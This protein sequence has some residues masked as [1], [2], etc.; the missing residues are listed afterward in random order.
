MVCSPIR[1]QVVEWGWL[2]ARQIGLV[3]RLREGHPNEEL[4]ILDEIGVKGFAAGNCLKRNW[5]EKANIGER[6]RTEQRKIMTFGI[7]IFEK[8]QIKALFT[9]HM[10]P[11][12]MATVIFQVIISNLCCHSNHSDAKRYTLILPLPLT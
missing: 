1:A 6:K 5:N 11:I 8:P 4:L 7:H 9:L 10:D 3:D 12:F 2:A